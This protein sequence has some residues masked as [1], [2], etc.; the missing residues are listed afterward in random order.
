MN[1]ADAALLVGGLILLGLALA[2]TRAG[3]LETVAL[4]R[5]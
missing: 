2:R 1:A 3:I 5:R 4:L